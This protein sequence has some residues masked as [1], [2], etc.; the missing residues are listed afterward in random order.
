MTGRI[1]KRFTCVL[2][3][4]LVT[5]LACMNTPWCAAQ[6][7][8]YCS[9]AE[10]TDEAI[11]DF[12]TTAE[13]DQCRECRTTLT[14]DWH[15]IRSR[16]GENGISFQGDMT[17]YYQGV[18]SGGI[19]QR[20]RY[21]AHSDYVVDFDMDKLAGH[22]GLFIK[23]RGESQ[24]A[25]FINPDTGAILP[26]NTSGMIPLPDERATALTEFTLTQFLSER[27]AVFAGKLQTL[28]GD[29]NAFASG[30]GK[31]QF[32]NV[33]FV[34][35][36]IGF[37]TIPYST[38]GAGF[39][40]LQDLEP[41]FTLSVID[42]VDHATRF[43]LDNLFA[44]GVTVS[45]EARLPTDFFGLPGH[46]LLGG[47]WSSREVALLSTIPRLLL[48]PAFGPAP[49]AR[50]SWSVY[51]NF[52]QH[53]WVDPCDTEKGWGVFGRAGIADSRTNPL[54]WFVSFGVGGNSRIEG[55]EADTFGAGWYYS[56]TS[57]QLPGV[58]IQDHG[59]GVELFYNVAANPWFHVTADL[60]VIDPSRRGVD[61]ALVFGIRAKLDL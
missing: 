53:L 5:A 41:I 37:R 46:Q 39:V 10:Q 11:T 29:Q 35:T 48:P 18:V 38:F 57:D 43:D 17:Q 31:T 58:V 33:A 16:F 7:Y 20:F 34:A 14:G 51:W 40:V 22:Q 32:M 60:Q 23:L 55:R 9:I 2:S 54:D 21:G 25:Q 52:D 42:P 19:E 28:D 61:N 3:A 50:D 59:Q 44:E 13:F 30:R 1:C 27:V 49:T 26:V 12:S 8:C 56:G 15:G 36:P 45:A 47:T 6:E 24:L 4:I